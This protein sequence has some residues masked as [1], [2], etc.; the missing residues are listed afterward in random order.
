MRNETRA[1]DGSSLFCE[2]SDRLVKI[3]FILKTAVD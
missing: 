2:Y 1:G 3:L